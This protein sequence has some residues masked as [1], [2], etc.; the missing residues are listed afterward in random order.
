MRDFSQLFPTSPQLTL[1]MRNILIEWLI[2]VHNKMALRY[3][4]L[5]LTIFLVDKFCSRREVFK[6]EYQLLAMACLFIAGKYEEVATPKLKKIINLCDKLY[7][8]SDV[9]KME[10]ELL[11]ELNFKISQPSLNWFISFQLFVVSN[12]QDEE[13]NQV[14]TSSMEKF[15]RT[16]YYV[17][18]LCLF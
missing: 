2:E 4:T 15:K 5:Y 13:N 3:E 18:E 9:L 6:S 10:S 7:D 1:H 14:T 12:S 16:S 8:S 17:T 11:L